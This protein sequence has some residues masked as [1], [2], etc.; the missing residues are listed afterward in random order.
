MLS[1]ARRAADEAT[2]MT[3][4]CGRAVGPDMGSVPVGAVNVMAESIADEI[5]HVKRLLGHYWLIIMHA[6]MAYQCKSWK[7]TLYSLALPAFFL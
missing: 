6:N 1:S 4:D 2:A 5:V 7:G 3:V